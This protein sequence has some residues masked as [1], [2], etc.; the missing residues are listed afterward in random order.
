MKSSNSCKEKRYKNRFYCV[1]N[2]EDE[3]VICGTVK[4]I[5]ERLDITK[6]CVSKAIKNK[7]LVRRR[8]TIYPE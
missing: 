1:Y 6:S 5:C 2:L 7:S 8:Y 3:L 4:Q